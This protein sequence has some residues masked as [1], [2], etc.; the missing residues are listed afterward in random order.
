M[1]PV[2]SGAVAKPHTYSV[3]LCRSPLLNI[4]V[5]SYKGRPPIKTVL[6]KKV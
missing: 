5:V 1:T 4:F 2:A 3:P 6:S